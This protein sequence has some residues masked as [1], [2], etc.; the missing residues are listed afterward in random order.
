M[1][2]LFYI[3]TTVAVF[4]ASIPAAFADGQDWYVMATSKVHKLKITAEG[5]SAWCQ[6]TIHLNM[7]LDGGSPDAGNTADQIAVMNLLKTPI[8]RDCQA[9]ATAE[10]SVSG[11]GAATGLFRAVAS[12]GWLF[13]LAPASAAATK[14]QAN[15]APSPVEPAK[16]G[17]PHPSLDAVSQQTIQPSTAAQLATAVP[18]STPS[19]P[20]DINYA[21]V[22]LAYVHTNMSLAN[23]PH[24]IRWWASYRYPNEF[25]RLWNQEFELHSL[26]AQAKADLVE[27]LSQNSG[28]RITVLINTIFQPY[29]FQ[30][31]QFP[32][33]LNMSP[34]YEANATWNV[35]SKVPQGFFVTIHDQDFVTGIPME[36]AAAQVFEEKRAGFGNVV[37]RRITI[38]L[39]IKLGDLPFTMDS[40]PPHVSGTLDSI[41]FLSGNKPVYQITSSELEKMRAEREAQQAA[42][43]KA[44]QER[45]E[46]MRAEREAQQA[47]EAKA[48][49]ERLEKMRAEREAQQ[50]AEAKAEQ[51]HLATLR[52]Q[53]LLAQ[54]QQNID[55]LSNS[56]ISTKLANLISDGPLDFGVR[57]NNLRDARGEALISGRALTVSM[58]VQMAASGR[59]EVDTKWPGHLQISV[60]TT[61]PDLKSSG[62]YLV[63]GNLS[64]PDGDFTSPAQLEAM[65]IYACTQTQCNEANNSA[66]IVDKKE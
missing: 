16:A 8:T 39:T 54:R 62:W 15:A 5:G 58:L 53:Q 4:V 52:R 12:G 27:T 43:A 11:P 24:I 57:L 29:N 20:R 66:F 26:L 60:P 2:S 21:S 34:I 55:F 30:T 33:T 47:A 36:T 63:R 6:Q 64:V 49:Q 42:D 31:H 14:P 46:K 10:L 28:Q 51:E 65:R 59:D 41:V 56:S 32:I 44:E 37:D 7:I 22:M 13:S 19:V 25:Q 61:Q 45:L 48:E 17:A 1:K 18:A 35:L 40:V 23:D 38:A 50:A 9:A 3:L